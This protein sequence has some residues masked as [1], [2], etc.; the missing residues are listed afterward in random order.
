M[1]YRKFPFPLIFIL[2][3]KFHLFPI[4]RENYT[5][6]QYL[7][8]IKEQV[9]SWA[10]ELSAPLNPHGVKFNSES[11]RRSDVCSYCILYI[12]LLSI[13][14][15]CAAIN[16]HLFIYLFLLWDRQYCNKRNAY[17]EIALASSFP[18]II[19]NL[20]VLV[21]WITKLL[22]IL[23]Y[24]RG[25]RTD[26]PWPWI[27]SGPLGWEART[28]VIAIRNLCNTLIKWMPC[29]TGCCLKLFEC[30]HTKATGPPPPTQL[31]LGWYPSRL[32][33]HDKY[34]KLGSL[35]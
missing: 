8:S 14:N 15:C 13:T 3:T 30:F 17:R 19:G 16:I 24:C 26:M 12:L 21:F 10:E 18:R 27:E 6:C 32:L 22:S 2:Y 20:Q 9:P 1:E 25:P 33:P 7:N 5:F 11:K 28:L 35:T 34:A 29:L 31:N 4:N 23:N